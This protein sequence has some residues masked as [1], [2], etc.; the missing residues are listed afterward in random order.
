VT[1]TRLDRLRAQF[2][3]LQ[4]EALVVASPE[5]MFYLTGFDGGEGLVLITEN[6]QF[7]ITDSR[8]WEQVEL[9][10]PK[11]NLIKENAALIPALAAQVAANMRVGFEANRL[12]YASYQQLYKALGDRLKPVSKVA[13]KLR[14]L[15]D[16]DE[17]ELVRKAVAA[18]DQAF[19]HLITNL[20]SKMTEFE[21]AWFIE[22]ELKKAGCRKTSFD[23]IVLTG[24]RSSLPHGRP[25]QNRLRE[26]LLMDF[27]G[28]YDYY[29]GDMTRTIALNRVSPRFEELYNKVLEAQLAAIARVAPGIPSR[30][31]D[32]A[33]RNCLKEAGLNEYFGH[34]TGHGVGL[35]IH[36]APT[37]SPRSEDILQP[38]MIITIEP[39]VYLPGWGG[40]RIEDVVLVTTD[41]YE[42]LTKSTKELIAI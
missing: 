30:E 32:A 34:G 42:V 17:I 26:I 18:G 9:Q 13:E 2:G 4:I 29:A 36:E 14:A 20:D 3:E 40:I 31:V 11:F 35:E 37:V 5:N 1:G 6:E 12:I 8:Y 10:A 21:V 27:G 41:G 24:N 7:I 15:K 28:F 33:A 23:S 38:G 22:N 16:T 39:G 25:E 19:S